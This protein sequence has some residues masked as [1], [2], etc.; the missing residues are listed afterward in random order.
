MTCRDIEQ[1]L[2]AYLEDLLSEEET[3]IVREHLVSCRSCGKALEDLKS[4]ET[5]LQNLE[6]VA[7]P[8]WLK[9]KILAQVKEEAQP[10]KGFFH[11]LFTTLYFKIP[12]QAFA[13]LLIT[14][15]AFYLYRGEEPELR[16]KGVGIALPPVTSQLDI[17]QSKKS[18]M[19][20]PSQ[21][22]RQMTPPLPKDNQIREEIKP[23]TVDPADGG[24]LA[25]KKD[26]SPKKIEEGE[27]K[28]EKGKEQL[29][30]EQ[31]DYSG[32]APRADRLSN[33]QFQ[34]QRSDIAIASRT[35]EKAMERATPPAL[36]PTGVRTME[37]KA[38]SAAGETA[39]VRDR[40]NTVQEIMALL[41]SFEA[42]KIERR[43]S[44][45]R[46]ILTAELPSRH[47]KPF[48]QK[49]E[50]THGETGKNVS[51]GSEDTQK[52]TVEIRIDI[53]NKL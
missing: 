6:E 21:P 13:L 51:I 35:R 33:S 12:I 53:F 45:E 20:V 40:H 38:K 50:A 37:S 27:R 42:S 5:L 3:K 48:L 31:Q 4:A 7:P 26:F 10:E 22:V 16:K 2:P 18:R 49:L 19:V 17:E 34:A 11:K 23:E 52:E 41:Q 30:A 15:L 8:P 24:V 44:G 28:Q 47:V 9:Q 25:L 39:Q 29:F 32:P 36:S 14:V 46:E 1:N 43:I